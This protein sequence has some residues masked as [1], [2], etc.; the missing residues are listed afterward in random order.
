MFYSNMRLWVN[1]ALL[2]TPTPLL[3]QDFSV[4]KWIPELLCLSDNMN[5]ENNSEPLQQGQVARLSLLQLHW[6]LFVIY[7]T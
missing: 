4:L 5:T 6:E 2:E 7:T 3:K 1:S